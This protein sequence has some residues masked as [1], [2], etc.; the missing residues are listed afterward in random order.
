MFS[1]VIPLYNKAHTIKRTLYSV[2]SQSLRDFEV[3]IVDDG[4][5]DGSAE[6]VLSEFSDQRIRFVK[7]KNQGAS[8]ARNYGASL[9]KYQYLIFLDGDDELMPEF[10]AKI[11]EAVQIFPDAGMICT[12][13]YEKTS[14][15]DG[16]EIGNS[17]VV[18]NKYRGK[19]VQVDFFENP[20]V[21]SHISSNCVKKSAYS[22]V[23]GFIEGV[24]NNEDLAFVY[25]IGIIEKFVYC[26]FPLGI[27]WGG[28]PGQ[29]T[30]QL[31]KQ[32]RLDGTIARYNFC[33]SIWDKNLDNNSLYLVFERYEMRCGIL[34]L[35]REKE[36][37]LIMQL[38]TKL[39]RS[40]I[41]IFYRPEWIL[42]RRPWLRWIAV[43]YIYLT[44]I[45]WRAHGFP[46]VGE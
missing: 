45:I 23:G 4:S 33:H 34:S 17:L 28:V 22:R 14:D 29:I 1:I 18:A 20:H 2:L 5:T 11:C 40:V 32:N 24:K 21:F 35:L 13:R 25:S 26:G 19:I 3:V 43:S 10:L 44:K 37:G 12:G 6:V 42:Y 8:S 16:N 30:S 38:H 31:T 41:E 15:Q 39:N 7:Q 36:Y 27:Y 46:V 9:A